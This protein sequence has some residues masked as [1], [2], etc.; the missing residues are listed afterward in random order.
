M[1]EERDRIRAMPM[2]PMDPAKAVSTVR[3]ILVRRLVR[4]RDRA[5]RKDM[6]GFLA[7]LACL[8]VRTGACS[9]A[10]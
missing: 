8:P 2:M 5:V 6:E 10:W 9:S 7:D 1:P 3:P 4:D